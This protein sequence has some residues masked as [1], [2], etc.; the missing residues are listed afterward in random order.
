MQSSTTQLLLHTVEKEMELALFKIKLSE[1]VLQRK[2]LIKLRSEINH[3]LTSFLMPEERKSYLLH[4]LVNAQDIDSLVELMISIN[5]QQISQNA[6]TEQDLIYL[7]QTSQGIII[8]KKSFSPETATPSTT[9]LNTLQSLT[10][11]QTAAVI[12]TT[13]EIMAEAA[14]ITAGEVDHLI[15]LHHS[16]LDV[17]IKLQKVLTQI[18]Q[19]IVDLPAHSSVSRA[20]KRHWHAGAS[21]VNFLEIPD[22]K[23]VITTTTDL[24]MVYEA[25]II[26][27]GNCPTS[28]FLKHNQF[29][30]NAVL[31]NMTSSQVISEHLGAMIGKRPDLTV[32]SHT[33]HN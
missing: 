2:I 28:S 33:E 27:C 13:G 9:L 14:T 3:Q 25:D 21:V 10:E 16:P 24:N 32:F 4:Q 1:P 6:Q 23:N 30:P 29:K 17:S 18:F 20:V 15:L 31:I 12:G 26:L 7:A 22:I 8:T 19:K 5:Q 11:K